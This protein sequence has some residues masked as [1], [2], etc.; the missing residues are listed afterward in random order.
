MAAIEELQGLSDR[1]DVVV[2]GAYDGEG[3]LIWNVGPAPPARDHD[4]DGGDEAAID[5]PR[6]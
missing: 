3:Y 5:R 6:G 4:S 2:V 1:V